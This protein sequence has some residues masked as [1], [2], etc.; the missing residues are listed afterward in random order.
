LIAD[1]GN[2]ALAR[3][4]RASSHLFLPLIIGSASRTATDSHFIIEHPISSLIRGSGTGKTVTLTNVT[5]DLAGGSGNVLYSD[6][7]TNFILNINNSSLNGNLLFTNAQSTVNLHDNSARSAIASKR[8]SVAFP[9][10]R[11][12]T[13]ERICSG[14]R[15]GGRKSLVPLFW[16]RAFGLFSLIS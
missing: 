3:L 13:R 11:L 8:S 4:V 2:R 6:D 12:G 9:I 15:H 14:V 5:A 7:S 10:W 16:R 1:R